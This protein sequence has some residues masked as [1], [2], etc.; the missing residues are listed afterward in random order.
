MT[1][2]GRVEL[3]HTAR[4]HT[5]TSLLESNPTPMSRGGNPMGG[6]R[7]ATHR[8]L[9][10]A[11]ALDHSPLTLLQGPEPGMTSSFSLRLHPACP[12]VLPLQTGGQPGEQF[13]EMGLQAHSQDRDQERRTGSHTQVGACGLYSCPPPSIARAKASAQSR[14]TRDQDSGLHPPGP[15]P[16]LLSC[17]PDVYKVLV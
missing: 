15:L 5:P 8:L 7:E 4:G 9:S 1:P 14:N 16:Q 12:G 13:E 11:P 17:E 6:G 3:S 2:Q 10:L